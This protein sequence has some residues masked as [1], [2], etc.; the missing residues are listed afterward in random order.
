MCLNHEYD[1]NF[2]DIYPGD[3]V[4]KPLGKLARNTQLTFDGKNFVLSSYPEAD[5]YMS[6]RRI[7]TVLAVLKYPFRHEYRKST[8]STKSHLL[9]MT[10]SGVDWYEFAS[11]F[12]PSKTTEPGNRNFNVIVRS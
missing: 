11:E 10:S 7:A 2:E 9:L 6:E 1:L 5:L 12:D 3:I 8:A 4:I